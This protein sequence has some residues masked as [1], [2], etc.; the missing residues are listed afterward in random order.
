[1]L[2]IIVAVL[3]TSLITVGVYGNEKFQPIIE[4]NIPQHIVD[5]YDAKF[6]A[7]SADNELLLNNYHDLIEIYDFETYEGSTEEALKIVNDAQVE[8][9]ANLDANNAKYEQ[10]WAEFEAISKRYNPNVTII[11]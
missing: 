5:K 6:D 7:I 8:L 10:L 11:G 4:D 3:S 1:M 9:N 2:G